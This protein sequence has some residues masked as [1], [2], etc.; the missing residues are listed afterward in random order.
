MHQ[1]WRLQSKDNVAVRQIGIALVSPDTL[2][3][4]ACNHLPQKYNFP[5][6]EFSIDIFYDGSKLF[7]TTPGTFRV[8]L[9][10]THS[11]RHGIL[12]FLEQLYLQI[13]PR[14]HRK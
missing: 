8:L 11:E 5:R 14:R 2:K 10:S 4:M 7:N 6:K 1:I 9:G 3:R 13:K 12:G